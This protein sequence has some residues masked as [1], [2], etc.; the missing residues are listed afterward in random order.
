MT[1]SAGYVFRCPDCAEE[2][3]LNEP[4]KAAIVESGCVICGASVTE[5]AFAER[6]GDTEQTETVE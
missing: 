4:M 6:E 2:I 5:S 3:E 1:G